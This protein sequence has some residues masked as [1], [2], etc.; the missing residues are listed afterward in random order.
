MPPRATHRKHEKLPPMHD[1]LEGR[2][3]QQQTKAI[4][5]P[6][7]KSHP[8]HDLDT[9]P[10]FRDLALYVPKPDHSSLDTNAVFDYK[11]PRQRNEGVPRGRIDLDH[12]AKLYKGANSYI[13]V[14]GPEKR[15][16]LKEWEQKSFTAPEHNVP[17]EM[18]TP[19]IELAN[20]RRKADCAD[21]SLRATEEG[22]GEILS[23][24]MISPLER[25]EQ[26]GSMNM[27]EFPGVGPHHPREVNIAS[28]R[29]FS[30]PKQEQSQGHTLPKIKL[31]ALPDDCKP[32]LDYFGPGVS[33]WPMD[34]SS[35]N[36]NHRPVD[37]SS[38]AQTLDATP[39]R[40]TLEE[41]SS[42]DG[43]YQ[44]LSAPGDATRRSRYALSIA[45]ASERGANSGITDFD[46]SVCAPRAPKLIIDSEASIAIPPKHTPAGG[47]R[48]G[49]ARLLPRPS[50][51]LSLSPGPS[52]ENAFAGETK[53]NAETQ[54]DNLVQNLPDQDQKTHFDRKTG[55]MSTK[56]LEILSEIPEL[57]SP[58]SR[59]VS[60]ELEKFSRVD[61]RLFYEWLGSLREA[62]EGRDKANQEAKLRREKAA[63][64]ERRR[65]EA[66]R[67]Q[68]QGRYA[69]KMDCYI[70]GPDGE[71]TTVDQLCNRAVERSR[72]R[73]EA[74]DEN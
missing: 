32:R 44:I 69:P 68:G 62:G 58:G 13:H 33:L 54:W 56:V 70:R 19:G 34:S 63:A 11:V 22:L 12:L 21:T 28:I 31:P 2:V 52:P 27:M 48:A 40:N 35:R 72:Q 7:L 59:K 37:A 26:D 65:K 8:T 53:S 29:N 73:L 24:Y 55:R 41:T 30:R 36:S 3:L 15:L 20:S 1:V 46:E 9:V 23:Q 60:E 67:K 49:L 39:A 16:D 38:D 18:R 10:P 42:N 45:T 6:I 4:R 74:A 50:A 17:R 47:H 43:Q 64:K 61:Q 14:S 71:L 66:E 57:P 25:K 51:P 5:E